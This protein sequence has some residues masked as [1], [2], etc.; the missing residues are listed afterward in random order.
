[1]VDRNIGLIDPGSCNVDP[2]RYWLE[3]PEGSGRP[4]RQAGMWNPFQHLVLYSEILA[5]L[6]LVGSVA[7]L[8]YNED[9]RR[10]LLHLLHKIEESASVV[11]DH[12][13]NTSEGAQ[14]IHPFIFGINCIAA[15]QLPDSFVRSQTNI[16]IAVL[17]SFL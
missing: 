13:M 2:V 6:F 1:M 11:D 9:I 3:C 17:R 12:L 4:C 10:E 16:Q 8:I 5:E 14:D 15:L 7:V